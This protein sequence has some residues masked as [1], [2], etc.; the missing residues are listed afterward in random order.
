MT[1][2]AALPAAVLGRA[3]RRSASPRAA[4]AAAAVLLGAA[5]APAPALAAP[6]AND[7]PGG[8]AEF[9]AVTAE[10]GTPDERQGIAEL[11]EATA[12]A[13]VP[14]CLG[15]GSFARTVWF[16]VPAAGAAREVRVEG[17]GRTTDVLD[18]AAFVQPAG[19]A[20]GTPA[21]A[22]PNACAGRGAGGADAG[23]EPASGVALRVPAGRA[24]L[25][26]VGRRGAPGSE[27]DER[28]VLSLATTDLPATPRPSGDAAGAGTPAL[29]E[30]A[31]RTVALGGATTTEEDPA[32]PACPS[33]GSVWRRYV[34]S[35]SGRRTIVADGA[36][37]ATLTLF[38]GERPTGENAVA[39]VDRV[40]S[41]GALALELD[42][43]AG[44]PVWVRVGTDRPPA[45]ATATLRVVSGSA[46]VTL[47]GG[48]GGGGG[49]GPP[50]GRTAPGLSSCV[51]GSGFRSASARPRGRSRVTLAFARRSA[52]PVTVDVFQQS[53][54]RRVVGE[55]LVARF[56][57]RSRSFAWNG[58]ANRRGRRVRDGYLFVRYRVAQADGGTDVRRVTLRRVRGRFSVRPAFFRRASCDLVRFYKLTRPVFGGRTNRALDVSYRLAAPARVTIE[59]LRGT[60][61]VGR[62]AERS[63]RGGRT[64]R[65]RFDA[66]GRPRGDYRFRLTARADGV[67]VRSV[68]V[69]RRL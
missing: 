6:P 43:R 18:L 15:P 35:T 11:R 2:R 7:A 37:A 1:L 47:G 50:L 61:V 38:A 13:G 31:A 39:C 63:D 40:R 32:Q 17:T 22:E 49:G 67:T 20:P 53:V 3:V 33:L 56:T 66:E 65:L 57:G 19:A 55:R 41:S 60:R 42:A 12:D 68:L 59:V 21:T 30:G 46:A 51:D 14:R 9:T 34:P 62:L 5:M 8:A 48:G 44:Q 16:R 29:G 27:E 4:L 52:R 28:A 36:Q 64:Y 24:V 45:D 69:S 54:G 26:Q 10:N 23:G 25:V 58:R